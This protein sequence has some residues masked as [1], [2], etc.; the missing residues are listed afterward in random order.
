MTNGDLFHVPLPYADVIGDPISQSK[1][2]IIHGFWL[3]KLGLR[4]EYRAVRV[5]ADGLAAYLAKRRLDPDWQGCNV[6]IPHKQ[7]VLG[8]ID[9]PLRT[10]QR[11]GAAN[12]VYRSRSGLSGENSD[13]DGVREAL[14][15]AGAERDPGAVCLIGAG[16]AARAAMHA[17]DTAGVEDLRI[18]VRRPERGQELADHFGMK[19]RIFRFVDA[20]GAM[21]GANTVINASPLGM[22]G[23][24]RMPATMLEGLAAAAPDALVFDMVYAPLETDLL[25][26][27][28]GLGMRA[29]DGLTMLI[30]QADLAF[31]LFFNAPAPREHDAELRALLS[32]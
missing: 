17:L 5:R 21:A 18:L 8:L 16:G 14:D 2:P 28:R 13:I 26:T 25:A 29:V 15:I 3:K 10:A 24:A 7:A 31:T 22:A 11:I 6:T 9:A 19:A 23:Q 1:S 30:G 20:A 27:A 12:C 4:A 32:A